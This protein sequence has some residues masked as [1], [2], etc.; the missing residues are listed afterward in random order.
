MGAG[1]AGY[2]LS[3][4]S[5]G[6]AP[7]WV[8]T[9]SFVFGNAAN[10]GVT[11]D[12]ASA[13]AHYLTFV[14]TST[15]Y[16]NIKT[17]ATTG[18]V[19]L[20]STNSVGIGTN[21]P[22]ATLSVA[23][24]FGISE[25]G[26]T[27]NRLQI[28]STSLG[29]IIN[30]NDNSPI[31]LQTQGSTKFTVLDGGNVG[32]GTITPGAKLDVAGNVLLSAATPTITFNS[33][34]PTIT[35]PAANTLTFG[36]NAIE[37]V[38]IT[39]TGT[40]G[41]NTATTNATLDVFGSGRFSGVVTLTAS[42]V[43]ASTTTGALVVAGG[44][45]I[46]GKLWVGN[47]L[48]MNNTNITNANRIIFNDP[49]PNEGINWTG[50]SGWSIYE[51]PNDLTTNTAG[52]LQFVRSGVRALTVST[53]GT[54]D[55]PSVLNPTGIGNGALVVQGGVSIGQDLRVGGTIY[56]NV[57]VS[58]VI[59]T[60]TNIGG[61]TA[62]QLVYQVATGLTGFAGPGT[63]GNVLVSN[64]TSA[65]TYNNT[66]TLTG[67]TAATSTNTGALQV[68]GGLG[69]GGS[70]FVGGNN[71]AS[72]FIATGTAP[73]ANTTVNFGVYSSG[74]WINSPTGTTGYL[75]VAGNG[76]VSWSNTAIIAYPTTAATSTASG[77]LQ[78]RGGAGI[79]GST[80]IGGNADVVGD[81]AVNGG[82]ITT[83]ATTFN[84]V[85]TTATTVNFARAATSLNM[86][87][88]TGSTTVRN[89]LVVNGNFTVQGTTTIVDSTVTNVADP[90]LTLGGGPNDAA[91][92]ADDN[93]DRGIA[94][95]WHNGASARTG[96][97]G[98]DD[99]T[100]Y[101]T[102]LSS[103]T[104]V[105]EIVAPAGGTNRGAID[106]DL[107]GGTTG[108]L[109][110]QSA[111]N[112]TGFIGIGT[113][114]YVLTSNGSVPVWSAASGIVAGTASA[115]SMSNDVSSTAP[116]FITFVSTATGSAGVKA[117]AMSGL[118]YIP[119]SG[120]LGVGVATPAHKVQIIPSASS[121]T[122]SGLHVSANW[123]S[124]SNAMVVF[125]GNTSGSGDGNVLLVKGGGARADAETFEVRNSTA[126]TF[127]VRGDGR[128]GIGTNSP[129]YTIDAPVWSSIRAGGRVS[130]VFTRSITAAS[131]DTVAIGSLSNDAVGQHVKITLMGHNSG[132][133]DVQ[134]YEI[135]LLAYAGYTNSL[136]W[137]ELP[138]SSWTQGWTGAHGYA[139]DIYRDTAAASNPTYF[140]IRNKNGV[141]AGTINIQIEYD[142][143]CTLTSNAT[144]SN[145]ATAFN[146]GS[147]PAGGAV[148]G[149]YGALE[150]YFPVTGSS[151]AAGG[152]NAAQGGIFIKNDGSVGFG[153][154]TP[155]GVFQVVKNQNA[156][157]AVNITNTTAGTGS[158]TRLIMGSDASAG[159]LSIGM[160]SSSYTSYANEAWVWASGASTPLVLATVGTPRMRIDV[161]GYV[162]IGS[163]TSV[164]GT[165]GRGTLEVNGSSNSIIANTIGGA[166]AGYIYHNNSNYQIVNTKNGGVD[167]YTNNL[168]RL[169]VD[170]SGRITGGLNTP[171]RLD[172]KIQTDNTIVW[173]WQDSVENGGSGM[174]TQSGTVG[175]TSTFNTTVAPFGKALTYS[176][177]YESISDEFIPVLPGET[178]YG[179][180]WA[181]RPSGASGTAGSLYA[182]VAT[183][184]KDKK[185]IDANIGLSY[186]VTAGGATVPTTGVWTKYSGTYTAPLTHTPYN[187][188]DG[189]PVRYIRPYLIV[190]YP[191][192]TIPTSISGYFIRRRDVF[193]DS[194]AV[195]VNGVTTILNSTNASSTSTGALIV[196]G[197]V[198]INQNLYVGGTIF[199]TIS[200]SVT[201]A[202]NISIT[203]DPSNASTMYPVFVSATTGNT[204]ARVDSTGFTWI[205]STNRLG[206]ANNNPSYN[207]H[208]S[209][210]AQVADYL[211][212]T[213]TGGAQKLLMGNQDSAGVNNPNVIVA[214]NGTMFF[215]NGNSWTTDGG[216]VTYNANISPSGVLIGAG[217]ATSSAKLHILKGTPASATGVPTNTDILV[218]SNTD[219][220]LTFRQSA[221][222]GLYGGL[223]WV[224]NNV[225]AYI[226][227][228][229]YTA[230]GTS[231]GSDSLIYGTY[232]DHIFQAST[233]GTMNGKTEVLR[234]TQ[235]GNVGIGNAAPTHRI[236][237]AGV[238]GTTEQHRIRFGIYNGPS[239]GG[240]GVGAA[241]AG[242]TNAGGGLVWTPNYSGYTKRSAGILQIGE[243]DYFRSGLAFYVNNYQDSSTDFAEA[244]RISSNGNVGIGLTNPSYKLQ[245]NG[246]F[247]ATTKSFVIDHPTKP[248]RQLRYGS[249]EGPENGVYVRGRLKGTNTI[250]LPDYWT[251][252]VDPDSI[253]VT[254]TPVGKHQKL[255]VEEIADNKIVVGNDGLFA[256]GIDC[257]Y[258]V[259][260]ERADV[261]KLQVEI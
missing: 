215:G 66:L 160:H 110:Y 46:T 53:T 114:G 154:T 2:L 73:A 107:A 17:A 108:A 139:V 153:T 252:L 238:N 165:S 25:I 82:D 21:A 233:S 54:I 193:R 126:T 29:A 22:A 86:G 47:G 30:Q 62:G 152:Y 71:N 49:G 146:A 164:Y 96:F 226:V 78:V 39:A 3:V 248:G 210:N 85:D 63:A 101:F 228:R 45:G 64:G 178:F 105:N 75:A 251:K 91:P 183:Y 206:I 36:T 203:D 212:I 179:E 1:Q 50:G 13:T 250:E 150:W 201:N 93:K 208:V 9:G 141:G 128:I 242:G 40:V 109:P 133:I 11:N 185:Q 23:G 198:G 213:N 41:I 33:S 190:N 174:N 205:P 106:A 256:K 167:I 159:N 230:S 140:R 189:G 34:G 209:G 103:A 98:F 113:N 147:A 218:D 197:G 241:T 192:G 94:F 148:G 217:N 149:V 119:S 15:G 26:G 181:Y 12:R 145:I 42:T 81:I 184:D 60:A 200:G 162:T 51:S 70:V 14:S 156:E 67:T 227:F 220:Y 199:G 177:Y 234:I 132:V 229:N 127:L 163:S 221:D 27:A 16:S 6:T 246:S 122:V 253:T 112:T 72:A 99:S 223:Q 88:V 143:D 131:G 35:S 83:L 211:R 168:L 95:K 24:S 171:V 120:N 80:Y 180:L 79:A 245:V 151:S 117:A 8:S 52:N 44:A 124:I 4:N 196:A 257:F 102:F 243:G 57:S 129:S 136:N 188:S 225:G 173:T 158:R 232:Q 28:T 222:A 20:P 191:S 219:S 187:T 161:S 204:P 240:S 90:I 249:L 92:S 254:L 247:A 255:F 111:P 5:S 207:L 61:G 59:S 32:V 235:A 138:H 121:D 56:G 244:V 87:A 157:T 169:W 19:F 155:S 48:D 135:G 182:G 100:G 7:Q 74:A 170:A 115:V 186:F 104:F 172:S 43:A 37:R 134:I 144:Q 69:I 38:R 224:D 194:G 260:A 239:G 77:S 142:S 18:M 258:T 237:F 236:D 176:A 10:V 259:W 214:A 123:G 202:T 125:D 68:A 31:Y 261:E 76:V 58:G 89:N 118:T 231:V 137:L 65:P 175:T 116:Q 84:L 55:I 166:A 130:E 216:A 195:A 97:F